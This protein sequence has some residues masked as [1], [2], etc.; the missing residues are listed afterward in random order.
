MKITQTKKAKA[1]KIDL[2]KMA[3]AIAAAVIGHVRDRTDSGLDVKDRP[4]KPYA[5]SYEALLAASGQD[6]KVDLQ[7]TG[8]MLNAFDL[9]DE[10]LR[11]DVLTLTFGVKPSQTKNAYFYV[12]GG[13][14]HAKMKREKIEKAAI[15]KAK[16][17]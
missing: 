3:P 14:R 9:L 5:E 12:P 17:G 11:G 10:Q 1:P 8:G 13:R 4:F 2:R 7:L 15:K 16:K 6:T